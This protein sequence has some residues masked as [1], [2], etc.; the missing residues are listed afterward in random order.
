MKNTI[1]NLRTFSHLI[2]TRHWVKNILIFAPLIFSLNLFNLNYLI[3]SLTAFVSFSFVSVFIYIINDMRDI[4]TDAL[5][6]VKCLRPLPSGAV[7]KNKA[8]IIGLLFFITGI[9]FSFINIKTTAIVLF[10]FIINILYTFKLK[11]IVIVDI[12]IIALG[13]CLRVLMGAIVINVK[14]SNWMLLATF[15]VSLILGFGK[16]RHELVLLKDDAADHRAIL[17]EYSKE[18]LDIMITISTGLTAISYALYVMDQTHSSKFGT[19]S[20]IYTFPLVIYGL[21]RYLYI[22]YNKSKGGSPEE[23]LITDKGIIFSVLLWG[24]MI[25]SLL[26]FHDFFSSIGEA[27][28][29]IFK[30]IQKIVS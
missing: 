1:N 17:G 16:R 12:F 26:Y 2:R 11:Q 30:I 18:I 20:L 24:M 19:E 29:N 25:I 4:E 7:T 9:F 5:H 14:L 27:D 15:C 21:F 28:V 10:Y 13:F 22:V 6:P 23:D 8:V 3:K